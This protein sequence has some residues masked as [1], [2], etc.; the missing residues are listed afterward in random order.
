MNE[1]GSFILS[2]TAWLYTKLF[3]GP[4]FFFDLWSLAHLYSGFLVML[5]LHACHRRRPFLELTALLVAYELVELAFIFVAFHVFRPETLKDQATDIVVGWVGGALAT[6]LVRV[7]GSLRRS[8]REQLARH[9]A[10]PLAAVAIAFEW[11]GNYGYSYDRPF[12]N[13]PGLC[14]WAFLLWS[15]A[16]LAVG[17]SY[18]SLEARVGSAKKAFSITVLGYGA[19]LLLVEHLGY[20]ELGIHE[21]GHAN[22]TALAFDLVHGT[23]ELHAFYIMAPAI[24]V[25]AFAW[26]RALFARAMTPRLVLRPRTAVLGPALT[27]ARFGEE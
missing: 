4:F 21:V 3:E 17:E 19:A 16:L 23:R 12:L 22:R 26:L 11:V 6:M 20:F 27:P 9:A 25:V 14:W 15:L 7:G 18:A 5:V 10:A 13:S 24:G 8:G 1:A 2:H